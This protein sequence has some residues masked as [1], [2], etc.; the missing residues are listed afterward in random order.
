MK[1]R[2]FILHHLFSY[3]KTGSVGPKVK[4]ERW[5]IDV[6]EPDNRVRETPWK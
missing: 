5:I 3:P 4:P 2:S 6:L 1:T